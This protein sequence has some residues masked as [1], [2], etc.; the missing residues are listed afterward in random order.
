MSVNSARPVS[1]AGFPKALFRLLR[2]KQW[3][4]N[5]LVLAAPLFSGVHDH[6]KFVVPTI[7]AFFAMCLASSSTYICNDLQDIE[8]DR[9]HPVKRFR[10]LVSGAVSKDFGL[11]VGILCLAGALILSAS[12]GKG[13]LIIVLTY[14]VMQVLYN[15]RLK[16][17]PIADVYTLALG[18]ILRAALGAAAIHVS[19][20]G[21]LLFCTGALALMLAFAKRRNEFILQGEDR[22]E[23]RESLAHYSKSALDALVC[24][25]AAGAAICYAIYTIES[26]TAR[27]YPA[28]IV[29][30][31]FVFYGITRYVFLVFAVNEG[32]EP[33]DVLF[34]DRH[35]I[36]SVLGFLVS[37]VIAMTGLRIPI[38]GH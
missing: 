22:S 13:S 12:L 11:A 24:M 37:A 1:A 17:I 20:S 3:A 9:L 27:V 16:Q 30:S 10:P 23:S 33:A 38:L 5:L 28:I 4:K 31:L 29:T 34:R 2:V 19:I 35:I 8:R 6:S 7:M 14:L 36:F 15:L 18:F 26:N 21:W 25:F 32:G